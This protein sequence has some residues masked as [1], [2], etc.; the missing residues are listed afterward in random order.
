MIR[1]PRRAAIGF[2]LAALAIATAC[3]Q[4]VPAGADAPLAPLTVAVS[5]SN[6][7]G[8]QNLPFVQGTIY[9]VTYIFTD[10]ANAKLTNI[11]FS[12]RLPAGVSVAPGTTPTALNC[13]NYTPSGESGSGTISASGFTVYGNSPN[14]CAMEFFIVAA[15]PEGSTPDKPGTISWTDNGTA[16]PSSDVTFPSWSVSVTTPPTLGISFPASGTTF[17]FDQKVRAQLTGTPG[18]GDSI[19]AGDL[20]AVDQIGDEV[21]SGGLI[22]TDVPGKHTLT[23]WAQTTDGFIGSGQKITYTVASPKPLNIHSAPHARIT[24][25]IKYLATGTVTATFV[26]GGKVIAT[27]TRWVHV[28]YEMPMSVVLNATGQ[29]ILASHKSGVAVS[30]VLRYKQWVVHTFNPTPATVFPHIQLR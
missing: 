24:F 12:D 16:E 15:T 29:R 26:Y 10:T 14:H 7:S 19:P 21:S 20:Y 25:D 28:G 27:G 22:P 5:T 2:L 1:V 18:T 4:A 3:I 13:G 23:V 8:S 30:L 9:A 17:D 11:S 6:M